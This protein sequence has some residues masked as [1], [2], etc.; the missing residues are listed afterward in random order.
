[1]L[2]SRDQ[3]YLRKQDEKQLGQALQWSISS[4]KYAYQ[5]LVGYF[6]ATPRI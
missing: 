5:S 1:M 3:Q 2:L 4:L 6:E